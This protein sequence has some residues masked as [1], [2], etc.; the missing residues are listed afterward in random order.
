M[1]TLLSGQQAAPSAPESSATVDQSTTF[2]PNQRLPVHRWFRYSAGFS[3]TWAEAVISEAAR[4]RAWVVLDPFAGSGTTLLAGQRAGV[5]AIGLDAHG[6]VVE[7]ARA[8]L[9]WEADVADFQA[10]TRDLMDAA[11]RAPTPALETFPTLIRRIYDEDALGQLARLRDTLGQSTYEPSTQRLLWLGL[12]TILRACAQAGTA[13]WQ[14]VLP[15]KT[16]SRVAVPFDAFARQCELMQQDMRTQQAALPAPLQAEMHLDD[17]RHCGAIEDRSVDLLVTSPPYPNNY[18]Y[19]DA[20]R[21]ELSFFGEVA[22]WADL[23]QAVR[24]HL[25]RSCSQ[26]T[27]A[28]GTPLATLLADAVLDPVRGE[29]TTACAALDDLRTQRAGKKCY[30]TMVAAYFQDMAH[31]L[32]AA[33]RVLRPGARACYVVGDSAPYGVHVPVER[34]LA[35]LGDAAGLTPQPF[36]VTRQRNTKW[37]N[38]KHRVPLHEGRL[39]FTRR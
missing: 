26:H 23:Q 10:A 2:V 37:K 13:P 4:G 33:A 39:W 21:L 30:H 1:A 25:M 12:V 22:R 35:R 18:D 19:A 34:W 28:E 9:A 20:T 27:R 11:R 5:K 31:H 17:A 7:V 38:R 24:Q 3:G 36:E 14:Y 6:F 16:K 29:L 32:Q 8:K 15:R